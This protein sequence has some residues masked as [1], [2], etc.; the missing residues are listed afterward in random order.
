MN[1]SQIA[2]CTNMRWTLMHTCPAYPNAPTSVRFTAQSRSAD[3]STMTPALPPSSSTT[4]FLPARSFIRQPTDGEPVKV[5]SLNRSSST[6]RSPS[7]RVI[8]RMLTAPCGSPTPS[9]ISA[10]VSIVSGSLDGGL[11]TIGLPLAMAGDSL[12][13][14]R[15]SGKLNGEIPAIGPI[16]NRRVM[17]TRSF[18]DGSR[19]SGMSSPVIR[20]ASSAPRRNV[21]VARSTS[22]SASR[23]GLPASS[24]MRR[25]SSSRR[26]L[27]PAEMSRRMRPRS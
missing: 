19:S 21:S 16:G 8:G 9:M 26:S 11:R 10:T 2:S 3:R 1:A 6:I 25:P 18:E 27:M 7:S 24:A 14:A 4:F 20:S 12:W 22:T 13:A 15:L 23:I 17:P 5:S